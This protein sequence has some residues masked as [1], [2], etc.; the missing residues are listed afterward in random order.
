MTDISAAATTVATR[1]LRIIP[2]PVI[3]GGM[4]FYAYAGLTLVG[5]YTLRSRAVEALQSW[6]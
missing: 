2:V 6:A 1:A 5:I 4:E 3:G